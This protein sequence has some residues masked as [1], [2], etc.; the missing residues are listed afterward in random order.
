M[1]VDVTEIES[2]RKEVKELT[3]QDIGGLSSRHGN[4]QE[5]ELTSETDSSRHEAGKLGDNYN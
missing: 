1:G 3:G 5:L 4:S 2:K